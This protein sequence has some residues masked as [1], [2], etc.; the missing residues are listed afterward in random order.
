MVLLDVEKTS[1]VEDDMK[2]LIIEDEDAVRDA[3]AAL[4]EKDGREIV[5]AVD[6]Q[7]TLERLMEG[8]RPCLIVLDL[9][10]PEWMGGNFSGGNRP[11]G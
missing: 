3:L 10:I 9:M 2:L 7:E 6:G 1:T 5:T 8:S 11:I 4:H